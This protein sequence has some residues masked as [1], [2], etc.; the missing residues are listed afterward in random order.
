MAWYTPATDFFSKDIGKGLYNFGADALGEKG[1]NVGEFLQGKSVSPTEMQEALAANKAFR[2]QTQGELDSYKRYT[3]GQVGIGTHDNRRMDVA[4]NRMN[5]AQMDAATMREN[6]GDVGRQQRALGLAEDAAMGRA[7]SVAEI[8]GQQQLQQAMQSQLAM[9]AR[10]RGGNM[11]LALRSAG[12]NAA[13]MGVQGAQN[14]A[15]LRAQEMATAR[16]QFA[17][18]SQGARDTSAQFDLARQGLTQQGA[19]DMAATASDRSKMGL[20]AQVSNQ[21]FGLSAAQLEAEEKARM[22]SLLADTYSREAG[23]ASDLFQAYSS[24]RRGWAQPIAGGVAAY[25]SGGS[26]VAATN[27]GGGG[28]GGFSNTPKPNP[29]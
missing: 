27:G 7:P 5:N 2:A 23:G 22:R 21:Q 9:A 28:G 4:E 10:A 16:D 3:P 19:R 12:Q 11:S 20:N 6:A 24:N 13:N 18:G 17:R 1:A 14:A 8:Q 26:S 25:A 15:M 29:F